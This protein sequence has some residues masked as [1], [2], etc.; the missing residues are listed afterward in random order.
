MKA[1]ILLALAAILI[2]VMSS[3]ASVAAGGAVVPFHAFYAMHP[4]AV[5]PPDEQGCIPQELPGEGEAIHLGLSTFYSEAKFCP[6]PVTMS[7]PQ[8]GSAIF[9]AANGDQLIGAFSGTAG[10]RMTPDG[11]QAVFSGSYWINGD[12]STGRFADYSGA[13]VY[14]G[15]AWPNISGELYFDGTLTK[16][17]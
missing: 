14:W 17:E 11:P 9:T 12:L 16:P 15:T 8:F 4:R 10:L 5:G 13:G 6:D 3:S 2:L 7:G 1:R